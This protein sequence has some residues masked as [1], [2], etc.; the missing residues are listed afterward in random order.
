MHRL[1]GAQL[2]KNGSKGRCERGP[3]QEHLYFTMVMRFV[4]AF[5][6]RSTLNR[7]SCLAMLVN[8]HEVPPI[9]QLRFWKQAGTWQREMSAETDARRQSEA[10]GE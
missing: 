6:P 5:L 10:Q 1:A 9:R 8:L 4:F 7:Y 3:K 2:L